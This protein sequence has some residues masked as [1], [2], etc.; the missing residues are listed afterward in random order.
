MEI[1]IYTYENLHKSLRNDRFSTTWKTRQSDTKGPEHTPVV[2]TNAMSVFECRGVPLGTVSH[3]NATIVIVRHSN[4]EKKSTHYNNEKKW[5]KCAGK[6]PANNRQCGRFDLM[7]CRFVTGTVL[8]GLH[9]CFGHFLG[10][11]CYAFSISGFCY[12]TTSKW[13]V[14]QLMGVAHLSCNGGPWSRRIPDVNTTYARRLHNEQ[15]P[16]KSTVSIS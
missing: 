12:K 6:S 3:N 16:S 11:G 14:R 8:Y 2:N 15:P 4:T 7:V 9:R 5:S 1:F 13:Y 10:S